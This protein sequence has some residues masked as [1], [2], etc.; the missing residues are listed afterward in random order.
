MAKYKIGDIV[1]VVKNIK[2]EYRIIGCLPNYKKRELPNKIVTITQVDPNDN[3]Y[4]VAE[5]GG[6]FVEEMFEGLVAERV[7][8]T[9]NTTKEIRLEDKNMRFKI[10]DY[11]VDNKKQT[12]VVFFEDGDI[13]KAKC[14]MGDEYDFSRG[15]EVCIMKHICGGADKYYKIL[16][17]ADSQVIEINEARKEATKRAEIKARQ[18]AK[19][20][21]KRK[22]RAERKRAERISE[23]REAYLSALQEYNGDVEAVVEAVE[24]EN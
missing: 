10:K 12:V 8:E 13:Q 3:T 1:R 17:T 9:E 7:T 5:Y 22:L 20:A 11:K 21:E 6:W 24:S 18:K 14:C 19:R 2:E 16:K 4:Q 15:L 23:I